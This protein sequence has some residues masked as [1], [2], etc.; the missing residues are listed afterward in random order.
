[1]SSSASSHILWMSSSPTLDSI[2]MVLNLDI[3]KYMNILI[4]C[5]DE[6]CRKSSTTHILDTAGKLQ[7]HRY[8]R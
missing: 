8:S 5:I 2:I 6:L 7:D 3:Q 1:M 4:Q